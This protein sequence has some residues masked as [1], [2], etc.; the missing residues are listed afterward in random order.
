MQ[1]I[2]AIRK[3]IKGELNVFGIKH[4]ELPI[5]VILRDLRIVIQ[6]YEFKNKKDLLQF[7][8]DLNSGGTAHTE[9]ELN[10]V[11]SL[12]DGNKDD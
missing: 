4:D 3:F 12:M 7:Y 5:R 2:T 6:L 11:R 1:R 10:R 9:V 8:L